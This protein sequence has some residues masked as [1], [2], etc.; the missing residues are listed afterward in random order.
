MG[1]FMRHQK[2]RDRLFIILFAIVLIVCAISLIAFKVLFLIYDEHLYDSSAKVLNLTSTGIENEL[3]KIEDLSF[4]LMADPGVQEY[5]RVI[6]N[7]G[8][9]YEEY[10]AQ[11]SLLDILSTY[12]TSEDYIASLNLIDSKNN[13]IQIGVDNRLNKE[14]NSTI[15]LEALKHHGKHVWVEPNE[16]DRYLAS[17]RAIQQIQGLS[18]DFLGLLVIRIDMDKIVGKFLTYP[19]EDTGLHI[20]ADG[21]RFFSTWPTLDWEEADLIFNGKSDYGIKTI[22]KQKY[23]VTL[24]RSDYTGWTYVNTIKYE[25]IYEKI[26][27]TRKV[28]ILVYA[29]VFGGALLA[30]VKFAK[31]IT[32]PIEN[33]AVQMKKV[34]D[35][36][37]SIQSLHSQSGVKS[38]VE[39][40]KNL[41][42]DFEIMVRKINTLIKENYLK[43][44]LLKD[45]KYKALQAQIKPHFLYNTLDTI[46]WMAKANNQPRISQM[47]EALGGLI[48]SSISKEDIVTLGEELQILNNYITIQ[49]MR[50]EERLQ[51]SMEIDD[52]V[53]DCCLPK[54][55]LQPIVENAVKYGLERMVGVCTIKVSAREERGILVLS[56]EDS[57]PG[58]DPDILDRLRT[59]AVVPKG[60]GIGLAN[61]DDRIKMVF[62]EEYGVTVL[63]AAKQGTKVCVRLPIETSRE[64]FKIV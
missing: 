59:G 35:G 52:G 50:Y 19:E 32:M 26:T 1:K 43:Q 29:V 48:R 28:L 9:K 3:K 61:I 57:G 17:A 36:D 22:N 62:G 8:N 25:K 58:L 24:T 4:F 56:V 2:L 47:V 64:V 39:E 20:I 14:Q 11:R 23:F 63:G 41:Y 18:L 40:V 21:D 37:F 27:F 5:L 12:A 53:L 49:S 30:G 33:L 44:I 46:N 16:N 15:L 38:S 45:T 6:K 13:Q 54:M 42:K 60:A 10:Q 31:S 7:T 55:T 34:E 51:F